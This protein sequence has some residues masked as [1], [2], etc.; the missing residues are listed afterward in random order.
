[1]H[2]PT[3]LPCARQRFYGRKVTARQLLVSGAV[4]PPPAAGALYAA[5]DALMAHAAGE[6]SPRAAAA[7]PQFLQRA[8]S[9]PGLHPPPAVGVATAGAAGAAGNSEDEW[10]PEEGEEP[11]SAPA[12]GHS[13]AGRGRLSV[14]D[15]AGAAHPW[16][17]SAPAFE[18]EAQ[19]QSWGFPLFD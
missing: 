10:E 1:M 14:A 8:S 5:L 17:A 18:E 3:L 11:P 7:D 16:H 9:E 6:G 12:Y 19:P 2:D 13:Q 15:V 4:A